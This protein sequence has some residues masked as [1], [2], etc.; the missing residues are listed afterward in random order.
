MAFRWLNVSFP[1]SSRE[2]PPQTDNLPQ[3]NPDSDRRKTNRLSE[4]KNPDSD[5]PKVSKVLE[6]EGSN[7]DIERLEVNRILE[8]EKRSPDSDRCKTKR[9]S[10]V[11]ERMNLLA[12][13]EHKRS[14]LCI[15]L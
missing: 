8:V 10:E 3:R 5:R 6:T 4:E 9:I 13:E 14:V 7:P 2:E 15:N 11:E 12:R 1:R